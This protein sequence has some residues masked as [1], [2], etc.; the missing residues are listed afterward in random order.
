MICGINSHNV[1]AYKVRI[2]IN[3]YC[4]DNEVA[5]NSGSSI[6]SYR[7]R[8]LVVCFYDIDM[9]PRSILA[10]GFI[11]KGYS[12]TGGGR[13]ALHVHKALAEVNR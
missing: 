13:A 11:F 10:R 5:M 4:A 9:F 6:G 12:Y 2:R 8:V 3:A 1:A 7:Y